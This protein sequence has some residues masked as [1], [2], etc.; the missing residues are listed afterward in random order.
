MGKKARTNTSQTRWEKQYQFGNVFQP[1]ENLNDSCPHV[2]TTSRWLDTRKCRT[3]VERSA[4][5]HRPGRSITF[6]ESIFL[7]CNPREAEVDHRSDQAKAEPIRH[8]TINEVTSGTQNKHKQ[9]SEPITALSCDM[10]GHAVSK[11]T[12]SLQGKTYRH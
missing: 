2:W 4:K 5:R 8:I 12:L 3:C 6:A 7:S 9:F 10:E 1:T 11:G